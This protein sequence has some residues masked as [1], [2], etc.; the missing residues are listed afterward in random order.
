M[1]PFTSAM[2]L[3]CPRDLRVR[4]AASIFVSKKRGRDRLLNMRSPLLCFLIACGTPHG[5]DERNATDALAIHF[6]GNAP[7]EVASID[8]FSP[9]TICTTDCTI[10]ISPGDAVVLAAATT[11]SFAGFSSP[12]GSDPTAPCTF[13]ASAGITDITATFV[14]DAKERVTRIIGTAPVVSAAYDSHGDLVVGTLDQIVELAANGDTRWSVPFG[15]VVAAGPA[16]SVYAVTG[17]SVVKLDAAGTTLWTQPL[18]SESVGCG[19]STIG[20]LH[21]LAVEVSCDGAVA[22]HGATGVT[23]WGPD[24]TKTWS[25][26]LAD[27]EGELAIAIDPQ[28]VITAAVLSL[29]GGDGIGAYQLSPVDGHTV[30]S[31]DEVTGEYNGMFA[32]DAAGKLVTTSSGHSEVLINTSQFA[33][34][35]DIPDPD[36]VP[37]GVAP[38]GTGDLAWVYRP[39]DDAGTRVRWIATRLTASGGIA[40]QL[41]RSGM[42]AANPYGVTPLDVAASPTGE[43]AVVGGYAGFAGSAGW[44]QTYAP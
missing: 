22:V 37:I 40:W 7:G 4:L 8:G 30:A 42:F 41:E 9:S 28:G 36:Y 29:L 26:P 3:P 39:S 21:C 44:V 19:P 11:S 17:T 6:A 14:R 15:A 5:A 23:R 12:C 24:G 35:V 32:T 25:V 1:R 43:I 2:R 13:T 34:H 38:A 20:F 31:V 33:L 10:P 16:D 27:V 18:A